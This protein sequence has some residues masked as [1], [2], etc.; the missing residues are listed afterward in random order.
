MKMTLVSIPS[1]LFLSSSFFFS[2]PS[3]PLSLSQNTKI[4]DQKGLISLKKRKNLQE[5]GTMYESPVQA[6]R[7]LSLRGSL[8]SLE[9][10]IHH[11]NSLADSIQRVYGGACVQM[12]LSHNPLAPFFLYLIK[13]IGCGCFYTLPNYLGLFHIL[14]CKIYVE[15]ESSISTY[16]RR[17]SLREFYAIIYPYLQQLEENIFE[18]ESVKGKSR[19]KEIGKKR[20]DESKK[21]L[22]DKDLE[23]ENE[24]GICME[25]CTKMVLP[26]CNHDM[27]INCYRD[28]YARSESCPFCRGN[29]KRVQSRDLWV[30]TSESDVV[31]LET[32]ERE[33]VDRFHN[34]IDTLPLMTPENVFVFYYDYYLV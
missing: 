29:L 22:L 32:L 1:L 14:I 25:I 23:R 7:S 24:C 26:N 9:A 3:F 18:E 21:V 13:W 8:K 2:L 19:Y 27:C 20:G 12:K 10:D 6:G 31:D 33:N 5:I 15:G 28:W 16:E 34:Y 11:A 17:A 4:K 30:L